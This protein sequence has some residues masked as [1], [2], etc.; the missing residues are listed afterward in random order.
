MKIIFSLIIVASLSVSCAFSQAVIN[1][2]NG[3]TGVNAPVTGSDGVTKLSGPAW[4]AD[5]FYGT[6]ATINS[7]SLSQMTDAG[8]AQTFQTGAAAGYWNSLALPT[9]PVSGQM[10]FIVVVWQTAAGATWAAA[11]G[12]G[13]GNAGT[14]A[15]HGGT[16]WAFSAPITFT[17]NTFPSPNS[18]L[19]GLQP[20]GV[21]IPEPAPWAIGAVGAVVMLGFSATNGRMAPFFRGQ[22]RRRCC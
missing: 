19:Q 15:G 6:T 10:E 5:L 14:Y 1:F 20:F 8:V 9:L 18:N 12:G 17:P 21:M 4:A 16:Q 22:P 11:T 2:A 3:A 13:A 7:L